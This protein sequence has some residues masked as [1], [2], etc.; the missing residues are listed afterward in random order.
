[1][2]VTVTLRQEKTILTS[3]YRVVST[4]I[5]ASPLGMY[6]LFVI[7]EGADAY[8][9]IYQRVATLDDLA[10]YSENPLITLVAGTSGEFSTITSGQSLLITN[11]S[12]VVPQ[13][14]D[15]YF[16]TALFE[17]AT[18]D[19][20]GDWL[21][22]T[23]TKPFPTTAIGLSWERIGGGPTGVNAKCRRQDTSYNTFLRRHWTSLLATVRQAESRVTAIKAYVESLVDLANTHGIAFE[24]LEET[25]F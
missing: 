24:G 9:E 1:M 19:P 14:F 10:A 11:A 23:T 25:V 17:V 5:S 16:T 18:V 7:A 21:T 2:T 6:P 20:S 3:G 15:T 8:A 4:I 22:V 12:T 13:W